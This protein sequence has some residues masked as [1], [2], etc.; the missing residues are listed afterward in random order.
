[1]ELEQ[2]GGVGEEA[3]AGP[4]ALDVIARGYRVQG[5]LASGLRQRLAGGEDGEQP[6]R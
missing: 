3:R 5:T 4:V 2:L 6:E 1:M